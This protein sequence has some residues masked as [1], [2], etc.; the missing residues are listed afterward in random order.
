MLVMRRRCVFLFL[1]LAAM[2]LNLSAKHSKN[3]VD[4]DDLLVRARQ[5]FD[6]G[7]MQAAAA[8]FDRLTHDCRSITLL[9]GHPIEF[10]SALARQ[11]EADAGGTTAN[12]R[13]RLLNEASIL[14]EKVISRTHRSDRA[15]L[16]NLAEA[17]AGLGRSEL[18]LK[19]YGKAM[20]AGGAGDPWYEASY[21]RFLVSVSHLTDAERYLK[22]AARARP[23]LLDA[24]A[25][26]VELALKSS[27]GDAALWQLQAM[28]ESS[29]LPRWRVA[30]EV[31]KTKGWTDSQKRLLLNVTLL[32]IA[33]DKSLDTV[34]GTRSCAYQLSRV[35]DEPVIGEMLNEVGAAL[36]S[37][38]MALTS[39]RRLRAG[40]S[41]EN[42]QLWVTL[43]AL[44]LARA[45][46]ASRR[47]DYVSSET[48]F[49]AVLDLEGEN[50]TTEPILGLEEM[51]AAASDAKGF[52]DFAEHYDA[53]MTAMP[54]KPEP[55]VLR[56]RYGY[57][58]ELASLGGQFLEPTRVGAAA[59]KP[60]TPYATSIARLIIDEIEKAEA[61]AERHNRQLAENT[62][63]TG[64]IVM[65][66]AAFDTEASAHE[67]L[68]DVEG[69]IQARLNAAEA[70]LATGKNRSA[71]LQLDAFS[72]N[73][74]YALRL[75]DSDRDRLE[76][77]RRVSGRGAL[78]VVGV[79]R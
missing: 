60:P 25:G 16:L 3:H 12:Q 42:Q 35:S 48:A 13:T 36:S 76:R 52:V 17:L 67:M 37:D 21:G 69:T 77:L 24:Q 22:E 33:S 58:R 5:A 8:D 65:D 15:A 30:V 75:S 54:I 18:A 45:R 47:G 50:V 73:T 6:D 28:L 49:M 9:G 32:S 46:S 23:S 19:T 62:G 2:A 7:A 71:A 43:R 51:F 40:T 39:W 55:A 70:F 74:S 10:Y 41:S 63:S 78:D 38:D 53:F 56:E 57:H 66:G 68:G 27:G 1:V 29:A 34:G 11:L 79:P 14:Y 4:C 72:K 64:R 61:F 44:L 26:L 31:M 20:A 59:P